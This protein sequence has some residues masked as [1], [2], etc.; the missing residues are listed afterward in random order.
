MSTI[1]SEGVTI[2]IYVAPTKYKGNEREYQR[3]YQKEYRATHPEYAEAMRQRHKIWLKDNR[4][5]TAGYERKYKYGLSNKEYQLLLDLQQGRC[6]ICRKTPEE[7]NE[8]S[9]SVDHNHT[10]SKVRG[11]LCR[12]CNLAVAY[13]EYEYARQVIEYLEES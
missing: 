5:K 13:A 7:V 3:I 9:L 4:A 11:L 8:R 1:N 12:R 6:A 2:G 10:T